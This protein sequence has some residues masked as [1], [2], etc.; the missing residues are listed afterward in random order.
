MHRDGATLRA[1]VT[2][3]T[4]M[5]QHVLTAVKRRLKLLSPPVSVR[6]GGIGARVR[7]ARMPRATRCNGL[8]AHAVT[9]RRRRQR[10]SIM[11]APRRC[12]GEARQGGAADER[13]GCR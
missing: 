1:R 2:Q 6:R 7:T 11:M 4:C 8:S 5:G 13:M 10:R 12:N 3:R 9:W